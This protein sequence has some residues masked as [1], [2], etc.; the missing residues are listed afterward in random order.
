LAM[1][2]SESSGESLLATLFGELSSTQPLFLPPEETTSSLEIK[3]Q[4]RDLGYLKDNASDVAM[5]ESSVYIQ[6]VIITT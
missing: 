3:P 5:N 4:P 1:Q 6:P 2:S